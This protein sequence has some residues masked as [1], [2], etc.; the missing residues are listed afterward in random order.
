MNTK[1]SSTRDVYT[2][3][4]DQIIAQLEKGTV[5]WRKPWTEAGPP[6]NLISKRHYRG[7]NVWLLSM[8]G[9]Q[10][11]FFLTWKQVKEIGGSVKKDEKA[12]IV[13]FTRWIEKTVKTTVDG[14]EKEGKEKKPYLRYYKVFNIAQCDN[15]A[16]DFLPKTNERKNDPLEMCDTIYQ[17]MQHRP[18]IHEDYDF[19]FYSGHGDYIN[20]PF[21]DTFEDSESYY[22]VLFHE[23]IH[24][25]GHPD[26]LNRVGWYK[27]SSYTRNNEDRYSMEELVAEMGACYLESVAG[28]IDKRFEQNAAYIDGWLGKLKHDKRLIVIAGALAQKATDNILN[29]KVDETNE[30]LHTPG[31]V[32]VLAQ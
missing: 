16:T 1:T 19:A 25:T 9:Y 2:I 14:V 3:I 20:M 30:V 18:E 7:I 24:S 6:Q 28:I 32:A 5:P 12:H 13:I 21:M 31:E 10:H 8:L 15:I 11:N 23:L 29:I 22:A 17:N 4:T 27:E 26:R